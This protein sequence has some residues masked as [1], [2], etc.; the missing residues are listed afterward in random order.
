MGRQFPSV[1]AL[2]M[3]GF[4]VLAAVGLTQALLRP[5][6]A[7]AWFIVVLALVA[8]SCAALAIA[9]WQLWKD[10]NLNDSAIDGD[11]SDFIDSMMNITD[12]FSTD[13]LRGFLVN[14]G[15]PV[16]EAINAIVRWQSDRFETIGASW[17]RFKLSASG[18]AAVQQLRDRR[19]S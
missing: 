9:M 1:L 8:V 11:V 17:D 14:G 2:V 19:L 15:H 7:S 3:G 12:E 18:L 5:H 16:E 6:S 4:G 13:E 10:R